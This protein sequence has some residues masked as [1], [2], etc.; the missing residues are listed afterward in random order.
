MEKI[1]IIPAAV[2]TMKCCGCFKEHRVLPQATPA[3]AAIAAGYQGRIYGELYWDYV[4]DC[5]CG[6][7]S[8][9]RFKS[10]A[11]C[12]QCG[13]AIFMSR[14][15]PAGYCQTCHQKPDTGDARGAVEE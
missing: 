7:R 9:D 6:Q 2:R 3:L 15:Y 14:K 1:D 5:Q 8:W 12:P 11:K 4:T 10:K 13:N